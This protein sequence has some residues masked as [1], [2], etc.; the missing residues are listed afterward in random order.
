MYNNDCQSIQLVQVK[1]NAAK[2][3][4]TSGVTVE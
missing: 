2:V 4:E 3:A 1:I